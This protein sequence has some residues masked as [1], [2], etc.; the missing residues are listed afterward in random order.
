M[1]F[2]EALAKRL[3]TVPERVPA[4]RALEELIRWLEATVAAGKA[5][6]A[7]FLHVAL[8]LSYEQASLLFGPPLGQIPWMAERLRKVNQ[9]RAQAAEWQEMDWRK[10][11]RVVLAQRKLPLVALFR[12]HPPSPRDVIRDIPL[13][14]AARHVEKPL[15]AGARRLPRVHLEGLLERTGEFLAAAQRDVEEARR[16]LDFQGSRSRKRRSHSKAGS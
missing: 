4:S 15:P 2:L 10:L 11:A 9:G 8:R 1:D 14:F 7:R 3:H 13:P 12:S 5:P 16:I 6:P